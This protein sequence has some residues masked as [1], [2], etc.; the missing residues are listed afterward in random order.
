M[1]EVQTGPY[2]AHKCYFCGRSA[3]NGSKHTA[4]YQRFEKYARIGP[5]FDACQACAEKAYEQPE[6]LK[7]KKA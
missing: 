5:K 3:K 1:T 7:E 4:G 6:H 2:D